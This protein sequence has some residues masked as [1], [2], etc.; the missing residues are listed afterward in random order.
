MIIK[1]NYIKTVSKLAR[2]IDSSDACRRRHCY[3]V[4]QH[5]ILICRGLRLPVRDV[6][7]IKI[8]SMLHDIGKIGIDLT[9]IKKPAKLTIDE[10]QQVRMH[11]DIG[12]NIIK[13][14]GF[15]NEIIP[16]VRHHHER[17]DGGGYP[18]PGMMGTSIPIGSRIISVADAYD[19]MINDRPY[20]KAM[21]KDVAVAE[22]KRCAGTQ[23]DPAVVNAFLSV[24]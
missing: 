2:L 14:L 19:A 7:V 11:P 15:L 20:R 8:A 5:S 22:L 13:Q 4:E 12:A 21:T 1:P 18:D 10:W 16:I 6:K 9:V 3:K 23:F 17:F 24:Y